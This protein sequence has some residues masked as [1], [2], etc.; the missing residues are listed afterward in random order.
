MMNAERLMIVKIFM[1]FLKRSLYR[2]CSPLTRMY[3]R[4][5]MER[6]YSK[7]G[8]ISDAGSSTTLFWVPGG[9]PLMLHLEG[10]VAAALKLRHHRVHAIICDGV[11]SACVKRDITEQIP[12]EEWGDTCAACKRAC[13]DTL[14]LMGIEHSFIGDYVSAQELARAKDQAALA[15]WDGIEALKYR[16]V[17][18][19]KN[20]KSAVLRYL[21]GNDL[22]ADHRLVQEYAFS[23][24]VCAAAANN[25]F[26]KLAPSRVFMSHGVYV[27]WGPALHTALQMQIPVTAW[28]ASYLP[29]RFYFRHVLDGAHIDF[30]SMSDEAWSEIG[31]RSLTSEQEERLNIFLTNRYQRNASFDM[32]EFKPY[33]GKTSEILARYRLDESKPIWGILC[34][35]NWDTV[36]DY[37]PML[38][39]SF[40]EWMIETVE[41][42]AKIPGVQW[43][44]KVHPAEAWDNPDSGVEMLIRKNFPNLPDNI[45]VLP[46]EEN[47]S[48]LDFY[49]LVDGA[50]TVYGTAGLELAMHGKPV[51]L[52][53]EAH[54]GKKGFSLDTDSRDAYRN[55]LL[56]TAEIGALSKSQVDLARQ[57][58][59]CYFIL[60]QIYIS[61]VSSPDS[62]WWSFQFD[63]RASLLAGKDPTVD[64]LCERIMDGK[65]FIMSPQLEAE[66][67]NQMIKTLC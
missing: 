2:L 66:V 67:D 9:M 27:D 18:I 40:N 22:P 48:P 50:V 61:A 46:A 57:Y 11:F 23:G 38:Y 55:L 29:S 35:I 3:R 15:K 26:D 53:G 54:Y 47:I 13:S 17:S 30:H 62:K 37:A 1:R 41:I 25:A 19:G 14:T 10:A 5:S 24:L 36:S 51:I 52:A 39:D 45:R 59:Y 32:K 64:F 56:Q 8:L 63:K 42:A 31:G 49:G 34:H 60:R 58:A 28:M 16:D 6:L 44:V 12:I 7:H 20:V 21:K 33:F 4:Y 43:L 65:D